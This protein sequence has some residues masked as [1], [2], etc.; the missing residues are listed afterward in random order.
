VK[1]VPNTR[2]IF[3]KNIYI[4]IICLFSAASAWS[5]GSTA[6]DA[7][8]KKD[9]TIPAFNLLQGDSSWFSKEQLPKYPY[10]AIF[11]FDP[12]CSHC[13]MT[14]KE[15]VAHMDSLKNVFFV[16]ASYKPLSDIR[17]FY[18]YYGLS[19]FNNIRMGRD[20]KYFVPSFYRVTANPFVALYDIKGML[21]KVFDPALNTTIEIP[22]LVAF[23]NKN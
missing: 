11:Y 12:E 23:V 8:Y 5:Q 2:E 17:G 20:P 1:T 14:V 13:Q 21:V 16:F 3:M 15:L 6:N 9:L 4:L 7:P 10:T 19:Q 18:N 22:Q